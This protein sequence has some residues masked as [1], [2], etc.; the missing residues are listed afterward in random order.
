MLHIKNRSTHSA[1]STVEEDWR[2]QQKKYC[3]CI[4]QVAYYSS[5]WIYKLYDNKTKAKTYKVNI[6]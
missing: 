2:C 6:L 1:H 4:G 5:Q 3:M